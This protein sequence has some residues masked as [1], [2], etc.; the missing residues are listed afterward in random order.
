LKTAPEA[1]FRSR[2]S[3]FDRSFRKSI[4]PD[5]LKVECPNCGGSLKLKDRTF[6]G[7]KVRCPKCQEPFRVELPPEDEQPVDDLDSFDDFG[8]A[9]SSADDDFDDDDAPK[10]SK[11]GSSKGSAKKPV[12]KKKSKSRG[13]ASML[14][15]LI[16]G[17][18]I[19]GIAVV[20]LLV[21]VVMK[22]AGG[23]NKINM[24]YLL[25]EHDG[26]ARIQA[27]DILNAPV[28]AAIK[29]SPNFQP[30]GAG[31]IGEIQPADIESITMGFKFNAK[32]QVATPGGFDGIVAV[33]RTKKSFDFSKDAVTLGLKEATHNG[34]KYY[35]AA[36]P[37][38]PAA[39]SPNSV[40]MVFASETDLKKVIEQ[41]GSAKRR[42]EFDFIDPNHQ[43]VFAAA[44]SSPDAFRIPDAMMHGPGA[45]TASGAGIAFQK[46][47][48]ETAQG[49]SVGIDF[50]EGIDISGK[51]SCK[52][53]AGAG[54][55]KGQLD[56]MLGEAK[57]Q[58]TAMT[59][60]NPMLQDPDIKEVIQVVEQTVASISF[61]QNAKFLELKM[62]VPGSLKSVIEKAQ[63]TPFKFLGLM[64]M[65]GPSGGRQPPPN[66]NVGTGT[67]IPGQGL[68][69]GSAL[70]PEFGQPPSGTYPM[71][72]SNPTGAAPMHNA[73]P[74]MP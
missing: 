3:V 26:I 12:K 24:A 48:S 42:P 21:V 74:P 37:F 61:V 15:L 18:S 7:K 71:P 23:G 65:M 31:K 25:P 33:I 38:Q 6:D 54:A 1:I 4:M 11:G 60:S 70:P 30:G 67:E 45:P 9:E 35:T 43:I 32:N 22:L 63:Q 5:L 29:N 2:L 47:L 44:P 46:S 55:L 52:D 17:I 14:P 20:G 57:T 69:P 59:G 40:T 19:G 39:Y 58:F 13:A 73:A 36:R 72:G 68:P 56:L 34:T 41:G 53:D 8:D 51:L 16:G 64:S 10:K 66:F 49:I 62:G 27:S 28:L 50:R